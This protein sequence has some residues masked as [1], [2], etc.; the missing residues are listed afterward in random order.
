MSCDS[1]QDR[2]T[3]QRQIPQTFQVGAPTPRSEP[4]IRLGKAKPGEQT[5]DLRCLLTGRNQEYWRLT[6]AERAQDREELDDLGGRPEENGDHATVR[7]SVV[8][9]G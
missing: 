2:R 6:L 9:L 7:L 1:A 3:P 5:G 4:E 8:R